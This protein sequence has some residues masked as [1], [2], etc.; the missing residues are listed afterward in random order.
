MARQGVA[1]RGE[2]WHGKAR[3]GEA[4]R[5]MAGRGRAWLGWAGRG[6]ARLGMAWHGKAWQGKTRRLC[7]GGM[8]GN[9]NGD[10]RE[11]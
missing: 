4:R 5:G 11:Y 2:A 3:R 7:L 8:Y 1:G 10:N 6:T 9:G